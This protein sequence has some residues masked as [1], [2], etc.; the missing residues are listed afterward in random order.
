MIVSS[1]FK[2][3][4]LHRADS[5]EDVMFLLGLLELLAETHEGS[6]SRGC[7]DEVV[8]DD[9]DDWEQERHC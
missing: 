1:A 5:G 7:R 6:G 2:R 8:V 3:G 4:R 9:W